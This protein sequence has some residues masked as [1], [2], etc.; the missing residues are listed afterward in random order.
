MI[1]FPVDPSINLYYA[2][3]GP[4]SVGAGAGRI[5]AGPGGASFQEVFQHPQSAIVSDIG[6]NPKRPSTLYV[7]FARPYQIDRDCSGAAGRIYQLT[8]SSAAPTTATTIATDVTGNLDKDLCANT[9]AV[10]PRPPSERL[11]WN[12]ERRVSRPAGFRE[13]SRL[14]LAAI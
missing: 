4:D 12:A 1:R 10:D 11:R 14:V 13:K 9:L 3:T 5:Y 2:G 7:S 6:I 8:R